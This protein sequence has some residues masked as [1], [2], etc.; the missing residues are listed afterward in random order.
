MEIVDSVHMI[1]SLTW[2]RAYLIV[3]ET[4]TLIDSGLPWDPKRVLKYIRSIGR[5]PEEVE[6]ILVTHSHPDH[7]GGTA[8]LVR[9]TGAL[10]VAHRSEG[11][12]PNTDAPRLG[13]TGLFGRVGSP[14]PF[15]APVYVDV[16]VV[17]GA[18]I[19]IHGGVSVIHTPGH[20]GGSIC[21]LL[22]KSKTLFSGDT[23]FSDGRRLS[24]SVPFPGYHRESYIRSLERL[25]RIE[26]EA[27][28]GGH[29]RPLLSGGSHMLSELIERSP[30]PPTWRAFARSLPRR[31]RHRMALTGE[32]SSE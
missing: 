16:Q 2:S 6:H 32:H 9:S 29:G 5:G 24:R 3:G 30:E 18:T 31:L 21:F 20:T 10:V 28:C 11:R 22:D 4:L 27:V 12:G 26:F 17:D 23:I 19:P 15:L 25:S 8:S 7:V 14:L 1:P 13:Y